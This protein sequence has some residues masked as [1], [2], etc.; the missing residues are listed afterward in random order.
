MREELKNKEVLAMYDVRG[1]QNYIFRTNRIKEIVGASVLVENI[2]LD[3]FKA[4]ID[5]MGLDKTKYLTDWEQDDAETYLNDPEIQM[6][7]LFIGGG[8]AFVLFRKGSVCEKFNK[9]LA[10]YVLDHT[11]SLQLSAAVVEKTE[12]YAKDY[13]A[14]NARMIEIK[15][16][17]PSSRPMGAFPF[18]AV[19]PVTGFPLVEESPY[20]EEYVCRESLLKL[21]HYKKAEDKKDDLLDNLIKEKGE[22]SFLAMIH[23]DGNNMGKRIKKIMEHKTDYKD[24]VKTMREI[25]K[26]LKTS[27]EESFEITGQYIDGRKAEIKPGYDGKMYRKLILAGDDI[28]F[29]CNAMTAMEAVKVFLQS[30]SEKVMY[31]DK[32]LSESENLKEYGLSACAGI[33]YFRSHFPFRS[34]YEVAEACCSSAKKRAKEKEHRAGGEAE[35]AIGC[36][37][38]FQICNHIKTMNLKEHRVKNYQFADR[39]GMMIYRPYFVSAKVNEEINDLNTRNESYDID[40]VFFKN[41]KRFQ[42]QETTK[43]L[44]SEDHEIIEKHS[45]SEIARSKMKQLRNAY[46]F[47]MEEVDKTVTFLKSRKVLFPEGT[48]PETWYDALEMMD[49]CM[50]EKGDKE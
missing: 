10:K 34:A 18:M 13:A 28:T 29:I 1:I 6:Q 38:D 11:Y 3:G 25:S 15:A 33:A 23:I 12:N 39:T 44:K 14:I 36:Y 22:N 19:D 8:N 9:K 37:L 17:M 32:E 42:N 40:K 41:L 7:V 48:K 30:V 24:A 16:M 4:M 43:A 46:A 21:K 26:N 2:I 27:F 31:E 49:L 5:E 50:L 20:K 47:G 45:E 35:G